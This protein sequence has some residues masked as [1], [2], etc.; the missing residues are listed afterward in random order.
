MLPLTD[1]TIRASFVNASLRERKNLSLPTDFNQLDWDSLD[2]LGWRDRKYPNLG[3]VVVDLDGT[4][5]G[6]LLRQGDAPHRARPQCSWCEDVHLP[7]DVVF[8]SARRAEAAGRN[9][10]T[11]GTLACAKFECAQNVRRLP[12]VAYLGFDVEVARL[13][14]ISA[15]REHVTAFARRVLEGD[16]TR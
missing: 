1:A 11:I 5:T 9:G 3:Y 4:P 7:N 12:P 6:I 2:F 14:R 16:E 8:Y 13:E 10:N 15:L